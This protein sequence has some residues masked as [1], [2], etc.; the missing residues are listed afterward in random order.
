MAGFNRRTNI[1]RGQ[2][3]TA[4][5]YTISG[6]DCDRTLVFTSNNPIAVT[7][8]APG[9]VGDFYENFVTTLF[10]SGSGNITITPSPYSVGF[11]LTPLINGQATAAVAAGFTRE[12]LLGTDGNWYA[13]GGGYVTGQIPGTQTND[14]AAAGNVGELQTNQ[15]NTVSMTSGISN[16]VV[17]VGLTAGD[18]DVW[19]HT[20]ILPQ[21]GC[22]PTA[23]ILSTNTVAA[24]PGQDDPSTTNLQLTF[25]T[26][27]E[28]VMSSG[29]KRYAVPQ[30]GQTIFSV[31]NPIFTGG[32]MNA[33]GSIWARRRR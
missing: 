23:L 1:P 26:A 29:M 7:L 12:I 8:P 6:D 19:A 14:N 30:P 13:P 2:V 11:A 27:T 16:T 5:S 21:A 28:Q 20:N 22:I 18:W 31:L 17:S 3:I 32:S 33:N 10:A 4:T 24:F 9:T 15:A 25:P